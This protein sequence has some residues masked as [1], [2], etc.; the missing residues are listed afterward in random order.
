MGR[1]A[2]V[3][4]GEVTY[5]ICFQKVFFRLQCAELIGVKIGHQCNNSKVVT[6]VQTRNKGRGTVGGSV[7]GKRMG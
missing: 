3:L 2:K 5:L 4:R 7:S 1:H 6:I